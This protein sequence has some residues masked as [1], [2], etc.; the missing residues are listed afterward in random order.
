MTLL[1]QGPSILERDFAPGFMIDLMLKDV[2]LALELGHSV[3]VR[4]L[5]TSLAAQ[6]LQEAR[7]IGLGRLST[8]AQIQVLEKLADVTIEGDGR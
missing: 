7:D 6:G 3:G 4:L 2:R 8:Q 1:G 5:S